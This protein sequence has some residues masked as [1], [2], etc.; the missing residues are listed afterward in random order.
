MC[1]RM[2]QEALKESDAGATVPQP[3]L[4]K[5][6]LEAA[7][8]EIKK[9]QSENSALK[10]RISEQEENLRAQM[11]Q[12]MEQFSS[13]TSTLEKMRDAFRTSNEQIAKTLDAV[14]KG[15]LSARVNVEK[16]EADA[17]ELG[18]LVN[19]LLDEMDAAAEKQREMNAHLNSILDSMADYMVVIDLE[20][21]IVMMNKAAEADSGYTTEDVKGMC[22]WEAPWF[23]PEL[24]PQIKKLLLEELPKLDAIRNVEVPLILKG[25]KVIPAL[26]SATVMRDE[27]GEPIG[28][29]TF[30]RDISEL[31]EATKKIESER[32]QNEQIISSMPIVVALLDTDGH[33]VMVNP[34]LEKITGYRRDE[35]LGKRAPE[36]PFFTEEALAAFK[37]MWKEHLKQGEDV[38]AGYEI[39]WVNKDGETVILSVAETRLK[40]ADGNTTGW[41]FTGVDITE[42]RRLLAEME[43]QHEYLQQQV[44]R[45]SEAFSKIARGDM[46]VRVEKERDDLVGTVFDML[47]Q[48][49][50]NVGDLLSELKEAMQT[51]SGIVKESATSVEQVNAGMQQIASASQEIAKGAQSLTDVVSD[52]AKTL[53]DTATMFENVQASVEEALKFAAESAVVAKT[54]DEQA[55]STAKDMSE[56]QEAVKNAF[57]AVER[58]NNAVEHI[59]AIT[60]AIKDIADQTNLL[61]LN[62]AIEAARAG[63][64]GRGFA[65]VAEEVRKLAEKSKKSTEDIAAMIKNV[66][67]ET[68]NVI[69]A[70]STSKERA[71]AGSKAMEDAISGV[72]SIAT[73]M[74]DIK[75][76]LERIAEDARRSM[77]NI[78]K[79]SRGMDDVAST[80]E[81]S[82]SAAEETSA[83]IEEQTAAVE[84]LTAGMQRLAELSDTAM[85][86]ISKFKLE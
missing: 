1:R 45:L 57:D 54:V 4:T 42:Q 48:T 21:E 70:V 69:E 15:N 29:V 71:A 5:N 67:K 17:K 82:A 13:A 35:I 58:L 30:G 50:A 40:D 78:A 74:S 46:T 16:L 72:S 12:F 53:K 39:P 75:E 66:Q 64:Y 41:L 63:E 52:S 80:A 3:K 7:K 47:N 43:T 2:V 9:L 61:A 73:M 55:Q 56:I 6:E 81:E 20:G 65:V 76:R 86:M 49:V 33:F 24:R 28:Y 44:E 68:K 83:A 51:V 10:R 38:A 85:Q 22:F 19:R 23:P 11:E 84:Q 36:L 37:R 8:R 62:A 59:G 14:A 27:R 34:A 79:V 32:R 31:K 77:E 18:T 25:G 60:S 26:F